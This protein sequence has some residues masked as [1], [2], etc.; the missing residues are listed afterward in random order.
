MADGSV[1]DHDPPRASMRVSRDLV[2]V[3]GRRILLSSEQGHG[4]MIAVT[5]R[6]APVLAATG[7]GRRALQTDA[8]QEGTLMQMLGT[9]VDTVHASGEVVIKTIR[10]EL[11]APLPWHPTRAIG[12]RIPRHRHAY[13]D[14]FIM[15]W[16]A[17]ARS[18]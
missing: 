18:S 9:R 7:R 14:E 1:A 16:T 5:A 2:E 10:A 13:W 11:C 6:Y 4:D 17:V 15:C 3:P 8:E 12:G